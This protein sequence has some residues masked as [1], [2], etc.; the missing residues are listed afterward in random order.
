MFETPA[1]YEKNDERS[2]DLIV[3]KPYY[4]QL[5][6]PNP[7]WR[8]VDQALSKITLHTA[9]QVVVFSVGTL[10]GKELA[11]SHGHDTGHSR[12]DTKGMVLL[13]SRS[14][15]TSEETL[16]HTTLKP[17]NSNFRRG[18]LDVDFG[19]SGANP[20]QDNAETSMSK[21]VERAHI[22]A[23]T[24]WTFR[25]CTRRLADEQHMRQC[26]RTSRP[27]CCMHLSR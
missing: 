5:T 23:L 9:N 16:L 18:Q 3:G 24:K 17:E 11:K 12:N 15:D 25:P 10:A 20:R 26:G 6:S 8:V 4:L 2:I 22:S 7:P 14:T 19:V 27:R 21:A 13:D 1:N